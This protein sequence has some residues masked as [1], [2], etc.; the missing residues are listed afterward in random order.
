MISE[1]ALTI[2][3]LISELAL[4]IFALISE[5]APTIF[6]LISEIALT[7]FALISELAL[8]IFAVVSELHRS[9]PDV[10]EDVLRDA[11]VE[12]LVLRRRLLDHQSPV[13]QKL[14]ATR[15]SAA[16]VQLSDLV[17]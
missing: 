4:T 14:M 8:T 1:L 9:G 7:I 3:A 10:A 16:P 2:F 5:L 11:L 15:A 12:T 17:T 6:A 13:R